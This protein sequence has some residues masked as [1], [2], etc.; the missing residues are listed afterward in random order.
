MA[1]SRGYSLAGR[2]GHRADERVE[3]VADVE[4]VEQRRQQATRQ[5]RGRPLR[6]RVHEGRTRRLCRRQWATWMPGGIQ[7][8]CVVVVRRRVAPS[9]MADTSG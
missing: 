6:P 4:L 8:G 1:S 5:G 2:R 3:V 9:R 7:V